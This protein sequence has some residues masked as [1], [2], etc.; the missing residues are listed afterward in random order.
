MIKYKFLDVDG[1]QFLTV[2]PE[3]GPALVA[4]SES[5]PNFDTL[6]DKARAGDESVYQDFDPSRKA[7]EGFQR[8][9]ERVTVRDGVVYFDG[10]PV[11]NALTR[12]IL[13]FM[14]GG[15]DDFMPLVNFFEKV[16]SNPEPHSREQLYRWLS[17]H[18]F[19]ITEDGDIVAYKGVRALGDGRY[20][21][22]S[23]GTAVVDG[24]TH[25]GAIPNAVGSVVE[26]PRSQVQ[27]DPTVGCHKGLHAGTWNYAHSF[28]QGATMTVSINPRDVVSVPTDCD[29]QKV[30][31]CRYTVT[32]IVEVPHT[33]PVLRNDYEDFDEDDPFGYDDEENWDGLDDGD[34][35]DTDLDDTP[36]LPVY[37]QT[38]RDTRYNYRSQQRDANGK[39]VKRV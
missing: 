37:S 21:S 19:P 36:D 4:S 18:D 14:E 32:D 27:H 22:I 17:K 12:H 28:A 31:V 29:D 5:H 2:Y 25:A 20:T 13:A 3:D 8:V 35:S 10:D 23:H 38:A 16:A 30:R 6:V 15:E 33:K 34:F 26:M 39:F 24:V 9:S 1:S 7:A 11:D